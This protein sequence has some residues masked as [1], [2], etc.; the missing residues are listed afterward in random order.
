MGSEMCIRDSAGG[1]TLNFRQGVGYFYQDGMILSREGRC[2]A[3]DANASGTTL[4][5]G[6]GVVVL[7]RLEDAVNDND[8]IYAVVRG[9]AINNDGADKITFTAP[10]ENGQTEVI[11]IAQQLADVDADSIGYIEAH[12]TG[13]SLGDPIEVAALTRAF[14]TSTS[15]KQFCAIGSA[16]T[17][18]GH[19]DAAAGVTGFLKTVLTLCSLL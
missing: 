19:T 17:N 16:K 18:F 3:F 5:Q 8:H 6:C 10:S 7:K 14:S 9:S 15:R 1:V 13:T 4:G 12:G 2:R 11:S